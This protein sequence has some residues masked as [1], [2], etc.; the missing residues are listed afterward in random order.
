MCLFIHVSHCACFVHHLPTPIPFL[1][2]ILISSTF[3]SIY[4]LNWRMCNCTNWA[5]FR[6]LYMHSVNSVR[7]ANTHETRYWISIQ[8]KVQI[9]FRVLCMYKEAFL[10]L[11]LYSTV[12][13]KYIFYVPVQSSQRNQ[14]EKSRN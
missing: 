6:A 10:W 14:C 3:A 8:N 4:I 1:S 13:L 5:E 2:S 7:E 11:I 12:Q 9:F